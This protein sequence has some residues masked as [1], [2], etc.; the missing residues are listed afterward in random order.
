MVK[1]VKY[2]DVP[3]MCDQILNEVEATGVTFQVRK[4]GRPWV[5]IEPVDDTTKALLAARRRR[6]ETQSSQG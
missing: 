5:R 1:L 2:E 3:A 4:G 6:R